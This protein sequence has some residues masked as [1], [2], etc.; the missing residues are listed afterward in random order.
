LAS[1]T[2]RRESPHKLS[3]SVFKERRLLEAAAVARWLGRSG[4]LSCFVR[5][6]N[7]SIFYFEASASFRTS[8]LA[9]S[10]AT[11]IR[12]EGAH[13]TVSFSAVNPF[14][15]FIF[16]VLPT[17]SNQ[18]LRR[19][20]STSTR[21]EGGASYCLVFCR[22]PPSNFLFSR[23]WR[24]VRISFSAARFSTGARCEGGASYCLVTGRQHPAWNFFQVRF[25]RGKHG[26]FFATSKPVFVA[27][28]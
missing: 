11:G 7:P 24:P 16:E 19:L 27:A 14:E 13:L 6:V 5:F 12:C 3:V 9:S 25:A 18:L 26:Y 17:R 28:A 22:Q 1:P 15:F 10:F 21:C 4:T 8:F 20:F 23:C 2:N